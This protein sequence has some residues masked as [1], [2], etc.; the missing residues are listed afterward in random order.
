[1]PHTTWI[2]V[3]ELPAA[4]MRELEGG[5]DGLRI[6]A[7][8]RGSCAAV[9][10][11]SLKPRSTE[12]WT[13][14]DRIKWFMFSCFSSGNSYVPPGKFQQLGSMKAGVRGMPRAVCCGMRHAH[15]R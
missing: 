12:H 9:E 13:K 7:R 10:L 11:Y 14:T 8:L 4:V 15:A 3:P 6:L 2:A 5:Q 1:V